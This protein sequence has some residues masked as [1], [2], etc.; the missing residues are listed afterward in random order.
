MRLRLDKVEHNVDSTVVVKVLNS[1]VS[2]SIIRQFL[3]KN[4][5]RLIDL[6]EEV[7]MVPTY[8]KTNKCTNPLVN[9]ECSLELSRISFDIFLLIILE[10]C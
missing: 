6:H 8:R 9:V 4:L 7:K 2:S 3:V 1:G 5:R 10:F